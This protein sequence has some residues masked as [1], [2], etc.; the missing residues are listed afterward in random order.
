MHRNFFTYRPQFK[1]VVVGNFQP[2]LRNLDNA[3]RRRFCIV[4]F[5]C[6]PRQPDPQLEE[7]LKVEWPAILSWMLDG[8]N[9]WARQGLARPER[10]LKETA[11]YFEAQDTL[12]Q[13]LDDDCDA[14]PGN[15]YK[16]APSAALYRSWKIYAEAAGDEPGS[17]KGF[18]YNLQ[19]R[20]FEPYRSRGERGFKGLRLKPG[21]DHPRSGERD[22]NDR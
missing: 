10:V 5:L 18:A 19:R 16:S 11:A 15:Q 14:E 6:K 4:P 20:G 3:T 2:V 8:R 7:K 12:G 13:W 9:D 17:R 22:D 1:L 21:A